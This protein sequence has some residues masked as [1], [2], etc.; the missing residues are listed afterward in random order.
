MIATT[1]K[2]RFSIQMVDLEALN[3]FCQTY[4]SITP[5]YGGAPI[6]HQHRQIYVVDL[7]G[8]SIAPI[9][10]RL[11]PYLRVKRPQALLVLDFLALQS[12]PLRHR[13]KPVHIV[14]ATG[15]HSGKSWTWWGLSDKYVSDCE[16]MYLKCKTYTE[17]TKPVL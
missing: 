14:R 5:R 6:K 17:R 16:E 3:L 13:T 1:Y 4:G 15:E 9:L 2:V 7:I 8:Q 12:N 10:H 11:L